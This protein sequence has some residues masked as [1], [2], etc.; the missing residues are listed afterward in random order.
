MME[1]TKLKC[2]LEFR[3]KLSHIHTRHRSSWLS[4]FR[5]WTLPLE[6]AAAYSMFSLQ[7]RSRQALARH[8]RRKRGHVQARSDDL[9]ASWRK[10]IFSKRGEEEAVTRR[11][12]WPL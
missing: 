8:S 12:Q 9:S 5:L 3:L 4:Y 1:D 7:V 2:Q 11:R 10:S 6:P